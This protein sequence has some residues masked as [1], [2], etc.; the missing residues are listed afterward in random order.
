MLKQLLFTVL[1]GASILFFCSDNEKNTTETPTQEPQLQKKSLMVEKNGLFGIDLLQKINEIK[2]EE[3]IVI[4]PLSASIALGMALNGADTETYDEIKQILHFDD[5][6]NQE[7]ND[8]YYYL[9]TTLPNLDP[10]TFVNITNSAWY[11][12]GSVIED[13]FISTVEKSFSAEIKEAD[14][15]NPGTV[16]L[17]NQWIESNTDNK[18]KNMLDQIPANTILYLINTILFK[19][20]W[21]YQFDKELT[22]E[23]QFYN[24]RNRQVN[25]SYMVQSNQF[26]QIKHEDVTG[27]RLPYGNGKYSM[28]FLLPK[29]DDMNSFIENLSYDKWQEYI[30]CIITDTGYI[31]I[32]KFKTE[33]KTLLNDPLKSLG[34]TR[35]FTDGA[36]FSRISKVHDLFISRVIHQTVVEIDEE[37]TEA[38]GATIIEFREK[39]ENIFMLF[40]NRPFLFAIT[41]NDSNSILFLGKIGN[42][43]SN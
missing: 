40:L 20:Q 43:A 14:F 19:G 34:M 15:T 32:P 22:K 18:I 36:D 39:S 41:E 21:T 16:D 26:E 11:H 10:K 27:V 8:I 30:N 29:D 6:T 2:P 12:Q 24:E 31:E 38:A 17:I 33:Y 5:L 28:V 1:L 42:P 13:H 23:G 4:S 3:N 37:G 35:S 9:L 25:C 7:I